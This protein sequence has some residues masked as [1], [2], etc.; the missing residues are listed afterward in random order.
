[1]AIFY[2]RLPKFEYIKPKSIDEA[3]SILSELKGKAKLMA[4]GTDLIPKLKSREIKAPEYIIDLKGIKGLDRISASK[5]SI[6]IGP[7]VTI[8]DVIKSEKIKQSYSSLYQ[9]ALRMAS[10]QIRNRGTVT[11]N[12]CNAVPSADTAPGLLT[13][14]AEL[15]LKSLEG[16]RIINISKFFKSPRK[17]AVKRDEILLE[18]RIP[19]PDPQA[20]SIYLKQTPR[21]SMDL[22]IAGVAVYE[23]ITNNICSDIRIGLGAVAPTPMRA[24]KAEAVMLGQ[25]VTDAII[26]EVA[27]IASSECNPIDDHRASAE[28]RCNM[29]YVLTKRALKQILSN[30]GNI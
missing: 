21:Q 11:G 18:I 2:R 24:Y 1:M 20:K 7:L 26:E 28:Y 4:G 16:E 25:N 17:S 10:P 3:L 5:D 29:V 12:I 6:S 23:K 30:D 9:A 19:K 14:N 13:F 27:Q 22:A 8:N 15:L